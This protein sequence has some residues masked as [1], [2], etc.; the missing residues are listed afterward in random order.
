VK[1]TAGKV[2][3][4]RLQGAHRDWYFVGWASTEEKFA[5]AAERMFRQVFTQ[6]ERKEWAKV[7]A[8][9]EGNRAKTPAR[10]EAEICGAGPEQREALANGEGIPRECESRRRATGRALLLLAYSTNSPENFT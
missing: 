6:G 5:F 2:P 7:G 10:R 9:W 8:A 4:L 3:S 1:W